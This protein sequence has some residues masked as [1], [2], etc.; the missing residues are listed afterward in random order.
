M[1]HEFRSSTELS[2]EEANR[3]HIEASRA[4]AAAPQIGPAAVDEFQPSR[5]RPPGPV[6]AGA[7]AEP[8]FHPSPSL[9]PQHAE[10]LEG[11]EEFPEDLLP[12]R[13]A[14]E[15]A[16]IGLGNIATAREKLRTDPTIT[17]GAA[18]VKLVG[19][20]ERKQTHIFDSFAKAAEKL[21]KTVEQLERS[22]QAP[23]EQKAG[24]GTIN[25]SIR[26]H[27][28]ALKADDRIKFMSDAFS[29]RDENTLV[30]ICGAPHYLAG[31]SK[32]MHAHYLRQLHEMKTPETTRRLKSLNAAIALVDRAFPI[33]MDSVEKALGA[34][35]KQAKQLK[36]TSDASAA[37][38]A[39][40]M[41]THE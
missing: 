28:K 10:L 30:A 32:E 17:A 3:E 36:G 11:Y 27:A 1:A 31:L 2:V 5:V 38:L 24:L 21:H 19:E 25:D 8:K 34:S 23:V 37:A 33:A 16:F 6:Q 4:F 7:V 18:V 20:A 39:A 35:F 15:N 14:L 29:S 40:I 41:G 22:L 26:A 9:N 13:R 12:V